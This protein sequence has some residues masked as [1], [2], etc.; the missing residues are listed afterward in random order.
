MKC[1]ILSLLA[2]VTV[3]VAL[4]HPRATTPQVDDT[5]VL[6]YAL[7]LEHLESAFYSGALKKFD[8]KA[9]SGA[10]YEWWVRRRFT[11]IAAHEAAH[12]TTLASVL[13][14]KATKACEYSFS[15]TDPKSFTALSQ[16]LEGVGAGAYTGAA[17]S[18]TS[19][20]Y[21]TAAA[22]ILATEARHAAWVSSAV[23]QQ[24]AWNS[25]FETPLSFNQAYTLAAGFIK[26]CP[27]SNPA[28]PF[29]AFPALTFP[30]DTKAGATVTI[31]VPDSVSHDGDWY[32]AFLDGVNT[33]YAQVS[34]DGKVKVPEKI[35]GTAYAVL[36]KTK[37]AVTDENTLAGPAV[38]SF[39]F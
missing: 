22:S 21:L 6:N 23:N 13:G 11:E 37:D 16:I 12:V 19:K 3:A 2:A 14:D 31:K 17:M 28:L 15:Y 34:K 25:A 30:A 9:F 7:T 24:S 5:T 26:S 18:I 20:P 36:S 10:G 35:Q 32:V 38:L 39:P 27:D 29:T 8:D 4:P 33:E 1:S